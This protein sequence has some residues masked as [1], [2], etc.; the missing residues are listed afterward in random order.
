M[1]LVVHVYAA[2]Y[3]RTCIVG[4]LV[5]CNEIHTDAIPHCS[6]VAKA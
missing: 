1:L 4:T 5:L 2:M 3:I 6:A